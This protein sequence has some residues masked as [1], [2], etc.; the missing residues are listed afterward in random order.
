[1]VVPCIW[2][3]IRINYQLDAI[4]YLFTLARHVSG[5]HAHLQERVAVQHATST[6]TPQDRHLA[7]PR[8]PYAAYIKEII[9]SIAP[10]DGHISPKHVERK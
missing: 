3:E 8:T 7:T 4:E 9:T 5:L 10:E 2:F 1:M 6:H